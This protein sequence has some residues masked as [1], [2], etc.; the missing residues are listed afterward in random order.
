VSQPNPSRY[1][2]PDPLLAFLEEAAAPQ[3]VESPDPVQRVEPQENAQDP[4][5]AGATEAERELRRRLER[6][7]RQI[8]RTLIDMTAL[9]GDLATLVS[10]VDDIK[11]RMSRPPATPATVAP[12]AP[13]RKDGWFRTLSALLLRI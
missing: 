9:K 3:P 7:E 4:P 12:I 13:A 10:A 1:R 5:A 2:E 8:D 6:A 11:K